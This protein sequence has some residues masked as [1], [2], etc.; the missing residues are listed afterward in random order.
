MV[1]PSAKA[2]GE[3]VFDVTIARSGTAGTD[4]YGFQPV[5]AKYLRLQCHGNDKNSWN[6]I[7]EVRCSAIKSDGAVTASGR[8]G[9]YEPRLAIDGKQDTRWALEG[10]DQW[11]QFELNPGTTFDQLGVLWY[12]GQSR[13]YDFEALISTDGR[14]WVNLACQHEAAQSATVIEWTYFS[15]LVALTEC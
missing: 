11:I 4:E 3:R 8:A 12:E 10:R 6:S 5:H 13:K 9:G 7:N 2:A 14:Q 15:A 1:E